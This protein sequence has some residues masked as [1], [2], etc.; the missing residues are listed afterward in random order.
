MHAGF[1]VEVWSLADA[2]S[3]VFSEMDRDVRGKDG[4]HMLRTVNLDDMLYW[5]HVGYIHY[6]AS[7]F[8]RD[9][10]CMI[11]YTQADQHSMPEDQGKH[12]TVSN[13]WAVEQGTRWAK[14]LTEKYKWPTMFAW[15]REE[16]AWMIVFYAEEIDSVA[17]HRGPKNTSAAFKICQDF[18]CDETKGSSVRWLYDHMPKEDQT[19]IKLEL[20]SVV[21]TSENEAGIESVAG[22]AD[23]YY[24]VID[25]ESGDDT[26]A[27]AGSTDEMVSR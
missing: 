21:R 8:S 9:A 1:R 15:Q 6:I 7:E 12:W 18:V 2:L 27:S 20:S 17:Q 22:R 3:D 4:R 26:D 23:N 19:R 24:S 10:T 5:D 13:H 11:R 25:S 14:A 16:K